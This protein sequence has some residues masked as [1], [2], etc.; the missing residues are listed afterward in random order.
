MASQ[1]HYRKKN[2]AGFKLVPA[3]SLAVP[4]AGSP[5]QRNILWPSH[6]SPATHLVRCALA[7]ANY[8]NAQIQI[9]QPGDSARPARPF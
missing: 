5:A 3:G 1:S 8:H 2:L 9:L 7:V 4:P 6:R